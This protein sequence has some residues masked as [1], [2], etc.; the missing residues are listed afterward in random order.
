MTEA[1]QKADDENANGNEVPE[2][3]EM[4]EAFAG[5]EQALN[6]AEDQMIADDAEATDEPDLA[7]ELAD[8]KDKLLRAMA[9]MENLRRRAQRD[10]ED[11]HNYAITKFARDVL[12]VS[13]N[14]R[15]AL[16]SIPVEARENEHVT[17]VVQG[18]EM[19]EDELVNTLERH[20]ITQVEALG[21]KFDPHLHQAMFEL[22]DHSVE[23]GT[24]VQV[25]QHGY[26]IA[27][28]LL[29]PSMVGIA[30]GGKKKA[31]VKV[32]QTA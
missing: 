14:L 19:T 26:Q 15:R 2:S 4:E 30:K 8:T 12:G 1:T 25:V 23:P 6:D 32:D 3:A 21:K 31:D 22:E 7:A 17:M 20:K 18:V 16:D 24:V 29:R 5:V 9:E 28:R 10:K 27:D 11:A 13:D